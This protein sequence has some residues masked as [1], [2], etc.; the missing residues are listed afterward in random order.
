MALNLPLYWILL[1]QLHS[2]L[3]HAYNALDGTLVKHSIYF[4]PPFRGPGGKLHSFIQVSLLLS[5]DKTLH[6]AMSAFVIASI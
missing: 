1:L 5:D 2:I 4:S 6:F 3:L